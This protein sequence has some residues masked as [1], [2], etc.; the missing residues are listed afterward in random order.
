MGWFPS[1]ERVYWAWFHCGV[2][3]VSCSRIDVLPYL[4]EK[5]RGKQHD[6]GN[7]SKYK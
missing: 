2:V 3:S 7:Q 1:L 6:E 4:I 5:A